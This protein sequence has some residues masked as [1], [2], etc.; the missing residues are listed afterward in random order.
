MDHEGKDAH[1][2][3]AALVQFLGTEVDFLLLGQVSEESDR[4]ASSRA[5]VT[6]EGSLV[7]P[8]DG[9]L[10]EANKEEDLGDS[11]DG[12][13]LQSSE[14]GGD[15]LKT[16]VLSLGKVSRKAETDGGGEV[17]E[18]GKLGDTTVLEL[19]ITK[20]VEP[21]LVSALQEHEGII[22]AKGLLDSKF[23]FEGVKS[24]GGL[25]CL[26]RGKGSGRAE[27][28]ESGENLHHDYLIG[29]LQGRV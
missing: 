23:G 22:E 25:A 15:I 18:E 28:S 16:K 12:D 3:G 19:N 26:G 21:L 8:P 14:A 29:L 10:E 7:L 27:E 1:H 13:L 6:R 17:A 5:E 24:R 20:A 11:F 9:E 4:E 2:G